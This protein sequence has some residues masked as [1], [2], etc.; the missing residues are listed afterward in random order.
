MIKAVLWDLDGTVLDTTELIMGAYRYA[1]EKNRMGDISKDEALS[2]FGKPLIDVMP[3]FD[4]D[5]ADELIDS[6]LEY[7][8]KKHDELVR[9][10]PGIVD[11]LANIARRGF[12]QAIVTSK[13]E[14]FSRHGL[15][16]FGLAGYFKTIIGVESTKAHKP[17]PA[18]ALEGLNRL[19][20]A[21]D[22]AIFIGDSQV[23]RL[24][25][26]AAGIP[27]V[28]AL[29]GPNPKAVNR[30]DADYSIA[31]PRDVL[32]IVPRKGPRI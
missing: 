23:D 8:E 9:P 7:A 6:Y 31:D 14:Q 28:F 22:E 2:N 3:K 17:A 11:A 18:P 10:F 5:R 24:C 27:F 15:E 25:A 32:N 12:E 13:T 29:W 21:P 1:F 4:A 26:K 19:K 30:S 16:L 20:V